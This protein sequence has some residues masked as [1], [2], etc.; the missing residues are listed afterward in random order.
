MSTSDLS[1]HQPALPIHWSI[2]PTGGKITGGERSSRTHARADGSNFPDEAFA[3]AV[4]SRDGT[5]CSLQFVL[6]TCGGGG[7]SGSSSSSSSGAREADLGGDLGGTLEVHGAVTC[8]LSTHPL[9][10]GPVVLAATVLLDVQSL[11]RQCA[12]PAP[13]APVPSLP[14]MSPL[15]STIV[16][17]RQYVPAAYNQMDYRCSEEKPV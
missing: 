5:K 17:F 10:Q 7:W 11:L 1:P 9:T 4:V 14:S 8:V 6:G 15:P 2:R 12:S 13:L 16:P 3:Q